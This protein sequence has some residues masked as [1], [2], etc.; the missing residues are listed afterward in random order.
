M[1]AE[2]KAWT[3]FVPPASLPALSI[4]SGDQT[5][6]LGRSRML[7]SAG[8]PAGILRPQMLAES[9]IAYGARC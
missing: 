7:S 4:A 5:Q 9:E 8:V 6:V 1:Y 2:C 3:G